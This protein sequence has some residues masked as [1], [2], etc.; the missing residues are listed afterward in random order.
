MDFRETFNRVGGVISDP[1]KMFYMFTN[2]R[3][4][5]KKTRCFPEEK[6]R[7]IVFRNEGGLS[8]SYNSRYPYCISVNAVVDRRE[9]LDIIP[10]GLN[11]HTWKKTPPRLPIV[12]G[13]HWFPLPF[14]SQKKRFAR[15]QP[16]KDACEK[17]SIKNFNWAEIWNMKQKCVKINV[18]HLSVVNWYVNWSVKYNWHLEKQY[19]LFKIPTHR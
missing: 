12:G 19:S 15:S 5:P 17:R 10:R 18:H 14:F 3:K 1:K 16:E 4:F 8:L 6:K 13:R 7:N 2:I 11:K 9:A